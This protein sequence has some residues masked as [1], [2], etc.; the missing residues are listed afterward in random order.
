MLDD[1]TEALGAGMAEPRP[2]NP[3]RETGD[4]AWA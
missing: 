1:A 3:Q 4:A 2:T